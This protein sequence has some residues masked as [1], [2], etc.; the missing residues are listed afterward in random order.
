MKK[1]L[2]LLPLLLVLII[3]TPAFAAI[4]FDSNG[5]GAFTGLT[6]PTTRSFT[7]AS[8]QAAIV[9]TRLGGVPSSVT[10]NGVALTKYV[11]QIDGDG[12]HNSIWALVFTADGSAHNAVINGTTGG[13]AQ[14][15]SY[16]GVVGTGVTAATA[17]P[18]GS[19]NTTVNLVLGTNS[20]IVA[21]H[22]ETSVNPDSAIGLT[23][24]NG[25]DLTTDGDLWDTNGA[26]SGSQ[27]VGWHWASASL[28]TIYALELT[29]TT[30]AV[31]T[32]TASILG[33][34]RAFFIR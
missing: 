20:W 7:V 26:L 28:R 29:S 31:A 23:S 14:F 25:G 6:N 22:E 33:L 5:G 21:G 34:V 13:R 9:L 12:N 30:P 19:G 1:L 11:D 27:D 4:A 16:T 18:S 10:Y 17:F 3:P 24:R 32:I 8:G 2:T 15:A